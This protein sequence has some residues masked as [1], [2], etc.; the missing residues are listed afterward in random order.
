ML[1]LVR[2]G[3]AVSADVVTSTKSKSMLQHDAFLLERLH[4]KGVSVRRPLSASVESLLF[5]HRTYGLL[6]SGHVVAP[7][8]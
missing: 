2:V 6:Q 3:A 8:L 4:R 7:L 5:R 1:P